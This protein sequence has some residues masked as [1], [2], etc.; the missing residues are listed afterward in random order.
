MGHCCRS[1]QQPLGQV[2]CTGEETRLGGDK[3]L[4]RDSAGVLEEGVRT[5]KPGGF[6]EE[7]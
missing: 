5:R 3:D 7:N 6:L 2:P 4:L 1:L